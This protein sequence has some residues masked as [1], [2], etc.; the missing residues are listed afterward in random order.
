MQNIPTEYHKYIFHLVIVISILLIFTMIANSAQEAT[1]NFEQVI[2]EKYQTHAPFKI[3]ITGGAGFIGSHLVDLFVKIS[4]CTQIIVLDNLVHDK[5]AENFPKD[6]FSSKSRVRLV[7]GSVLDAQALNDLLAAE[8]TIKYVFHLAALVSVT[9]SMQRSTEYSRTNSEGTLQ[10]LKSVAKHDKI[11]KVIFA[12]SATVYGN[13]AQVP[14]VEGTTLACDSVYCQTKLDGEA[15]CRMFAGRSKFS[16]AAL[17]LFNVF[18]ERQ[19][20]HLPHSPVLP[21][22]IHTALQGKPIELN[23]GSQIRDFVYVKDVALAMAHV[24]NLDTPASS[25]D[26]YNVGYGHGMSL[27][28]LAH[29]ILKIADKSTSLVKIS[30]ESASSGSDISV[31]SVQKLVNTGWQPKYSF[32]AALQQTIMYYKNKK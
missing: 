27:L 28:E 25:Y 14:K 18:G 8:P 30:G 26:V 21:K 15:Y 24:A 2:V 16:C 6:V 22:F 32:H 11:A 19:V 9:E 31:A 29:N 23:G 7:Q 4:T 1:A 13:S 17:R 12:S 10:L 3:L 20:E 5:T